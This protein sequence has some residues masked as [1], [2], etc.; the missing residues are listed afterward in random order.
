MYWVE[1]QAGKITGKGQSPALCEG[2]TEVTEGIYNL[3]TRLP[4]D[5]EADM[6]GNIISVTPAPEPEPKPPE[7]TTEEILLAALLEIQE[8]KQKV[9]A[10]EGN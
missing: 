8:L 7:P 3:L 2:Q 4:A 10:L 1:I 5:Y 6:E 9:A